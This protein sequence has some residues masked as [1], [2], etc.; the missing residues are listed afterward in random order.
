MEFRK[1]V[2]YGYVSPVSKKNSP[3]DSKPLSINSNYINTIIWYL[4]TRKADD[5][6][7]QLLLQISGASG[8]YRDVSPIFKEDMKQ[9]IDEISEKVKNLEVIDGCVNIKFDSNDENFNVQQMTGCIKVFLKDLLAF[10]GKKV[11]YDNIFII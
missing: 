3:R 1:H 5:K 8:S 10:L 4:R 2:K 9:F 6:S 7:C 11:S